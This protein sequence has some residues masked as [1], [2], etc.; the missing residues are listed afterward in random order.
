MPKVFVL[1][2]SLFAVLIAN[3]GCNQLQQFVGR[4][5][6]LSSN[7]INETDGYPP[8]PL[9]LVEKSDYYGVLNGNFDMNLMFMGVGYT[10][11]SPEWDVM[12]FDFKFAY[13]ATIVSGVS[14]VCDPE[15]WF[16]HF[17]PNLTSTIEQKI[18]NTKGIISI[19]FFGI[20]GV[21]G[22]HI[23]PHGKG[24]LAKITFK[25][26]FEQIPPPFTGPTCTLSIVNSTIAGFPHPERDYSP[27]NGTSSSTSIP[28]QVENG[29]Y[30]A[31]V[32]FA[33]G[34]DIF[35][36]DEI[37]WGKGCNMPT[38]LLC[39]QKSMEVCALVQYN[40]WPYQQKDVAFEV[41]DPH[42][43]VWSLSYNKTDAN[44]IA[45]IFL[46]LP[47]P[48][49]DPEY[50]FGVWK[51]EAETAIAYR[52]YNDTMEFNYDYRVR[53]WETTLNKTEYNHQE[54]IHMTT[55][56]GTLGT[57]TFRVLFTATSTDV[58]GVPFAFVYVSQEIGGA[59]WNTFRNDS[60]SLDL[61]IPKFARG[62]YP[63]TVWLGVMSSWPTSDGEAYYPTRY[64]ETIVDFN[65]L[66]S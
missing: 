37:G 66:P 49:D 47:W 28:H 50:Y 34:V 4:A 13:N 58:T 24:R 27:W 15:S 5:Y 9:L 53:I 17:W 25:A 3:L 7:I 22:T 63:A 33:T 45:H 8:E 62:G 10:D 46:R 16:A 18:D 1:L 31:P 42:G 26:I 48:C 44:G 52:I 59:T 64:P 51:I 2:V 61:Y 57:H 29:V 12:G 14:V 41:I 6:D 19:S 60:I 55:K 56:Y 40:S 23:A 11:L 21:Y 20:S 32:L 38:D 43:K 30:H 36:Y 39:P 35:Q 54:R 65:I